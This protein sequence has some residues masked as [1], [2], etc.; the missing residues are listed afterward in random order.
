[1][2][3]TLDDIGLPSRQRSWMAFWPDRWSALALLLALLVALP[4]MVV[5]LSLLVPNAEVWRHL[6]STVLAGYIAHTLVLALGVAIGVSVILTMT[7]G[8]RCCA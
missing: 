3:S 5:F 7:L 4:V 2:R 8:R 6:A 1:M